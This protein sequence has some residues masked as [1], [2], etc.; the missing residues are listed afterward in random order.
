[1]PVMCSKQAF[2]LRLG[3]LAYLLLEQ[4]T[5]RPTLT[6]CPPLPSL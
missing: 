3:F 2:T 6:V 4:T 1:M 5:A